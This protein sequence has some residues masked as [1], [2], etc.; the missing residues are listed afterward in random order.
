MYLP[1]NMKPDSYLILH[2]QLL[3]SDMSSLLVC[4]VF[5]MIEEQQL[6]VSD[7]LTYDSFFLFSFLG[8]RF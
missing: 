7:L 2:E 3:V 4:F 5:R 8:E 1:E 6:F